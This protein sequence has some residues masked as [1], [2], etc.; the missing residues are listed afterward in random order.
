MVWRLLTT[1]N[2]R[3]LYALRLTTHTFVYTHTRTLIVEANKARSATEIKQRIKRRVA[4]RNSWKVNGV[5]NDNAVPSLMETLEFMVGLA[6]FNP[7]SQEELDDDFPV[8]SIDW[9]RLQTIPTDDKIQ[10][11][12]LG[13]AS[14][15]VQMNGCNILCDPVFSDRCSPST[16]FGPLRYRPAP[17]SSVQELCIKLHHPI[18]LVLI[19]HNHYDHLDYSTV[20]EI[21]KHSPSTQF[22]VPLGLLAW[23]RKHVS[24]S[25]SLYELDWHE[26]ME[27]QPSRNKR[28]AT[29][30]TTESDASSLLRVTSIPMRHWTNRTGDRDK[31]LWCGYSLVASGAIASDNCNVSF[32]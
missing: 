32:G 9:E 18:D 11:T 8:L 15:L 16:W 2:S 22:V 27:Y 13:H 20:K 25:V 31:T 7:P 19:S 10:I 23:F 28:V 26:S 14:L 17:V 6:R 3:R 12:W 24:P 21:C 5:V 30:A 4:E 29:I 1:A